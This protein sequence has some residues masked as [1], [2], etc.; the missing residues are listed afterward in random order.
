[1]DVKLVDEAHTNR[2]CQLAAIDYCCLNFKLP[3]ECRNS[4]VKCTW[5]ENERIVVAK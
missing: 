2:I 4:G 1:M 3:P 5:D